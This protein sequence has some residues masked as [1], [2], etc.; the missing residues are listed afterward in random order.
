M[1]HPLCG[2]SDIPCFLLPFYYISLYAN[3]RSWAIHNPALSGVFTLA[4]S[5]DCE[6]RAPTT[7]FLLHTM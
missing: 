7:T 2:P 6:T 3:G 4:N 1:E 5:F